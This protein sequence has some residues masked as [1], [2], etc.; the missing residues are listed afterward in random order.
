MKEVNYDLQKTFQL[1]WTRNTE[2]EAALL[3][4]YMK[5]NGG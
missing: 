2:N 3:E 5:E 1:Q 4:Y